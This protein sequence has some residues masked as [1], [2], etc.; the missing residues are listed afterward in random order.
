MSCLH[1]AAIIRG[2]CGSVDNHFRAV[3][4][5]HLFQYEELDSRGIA[6]RRILRLL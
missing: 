4:Y 6:E 2:A 3:F 5:D 1:H